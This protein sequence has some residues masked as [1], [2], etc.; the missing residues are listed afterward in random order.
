MWLSIH[1]HPAK[2]CGH[3]YVYFQFMGLDDFLNYPQ[4]AI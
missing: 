1:K 4:V 3:I 2:T